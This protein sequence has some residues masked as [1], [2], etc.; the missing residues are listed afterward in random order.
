VVGAIQQPAR[1]ALVPS[2][3]PR[4]HLMNAVALSG[5]VW[6]IAKTGGPALAGIAAMI[7]GNASALF[8]EAAMYGC[9]A[10]ALTRVRLHSV[11]LES[12][13]GRWAKGKRRGMDWLE[14][15]RGYS[16]LVQNPVIGWLAILSLVPILF[17]LAHQTLAPIFAKDVLEIGPGGLGLLFGAPAIG[18]VIGTLIVA[19]SDDLRH[20]GLI[21]LWGVVLLGISTV[22]YGASSVLWLSLFALV[23]HG[24]AHV[25]YRTIS[26]TLLQ[27]HTP[28]EYRGRVMA[29]WAADRGLHPISTMVI[30]LIAAAWGAQV[31]VILSGLGCVIVAL[32]VA[33]ASRT[34]RDL[35]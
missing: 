1:Q 21:T 6:T 29:V 30:A 16:Y 33:A 20:K 31:A 32:M 7:G 26:Q 10:A 23:L 25:A 35:D 18:S 28:D 27:I 34:I 15:F 3:V 2:V 22:L 17:S 11:D 14:G 8:L 5:S 9:G 13:G 4:E 19:S 12:L 24:F